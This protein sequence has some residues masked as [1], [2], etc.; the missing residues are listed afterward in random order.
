MPLGRVSVHRR[1]VAERL[2]ALTEIFISVIIASAPTWTGLYKTDPGLD[3]SDLPI[4]LHW[5]RKLTPT[6]VWTTLF[7]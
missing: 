5:N 6:L 4:L 7:T 1:S 3:Q 2:E